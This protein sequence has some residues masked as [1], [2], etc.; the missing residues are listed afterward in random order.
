MTD[1]I[2][3]AAQ[4]VLGLPRR[5]SYEGDGTYA[6]VSAAAAHVGTVLSQVVT[7]SVAG[8]TSALNVEPFRELAV[9][10]NVT[11][12]GTTITFR[13]QRLAADGVTWFDIGWAPAAVTAIGTLST[14]VAIGGTVNACVGSL[15]RLVWSSVTGSFTFGAS[16][17]GKS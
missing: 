14:S 1:V 15:V 8:Q 13:L 5:Y 9:D 3:N 10:L 7:T 17:L 11:A 6:E 4:Q 2:N 12:A 16:V